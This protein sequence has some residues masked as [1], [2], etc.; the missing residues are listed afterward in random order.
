[1]FP[2]SAKNRILVSKCALGKRRFSDL[3]NVQNRVIRY[4][5]LG[6]ERFGFGASSDN[7][8]NAISF[9]PENELAAQKEGKYPK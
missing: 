9:A 1:M 4:V 6:C 7:I 3:L 5:C 8:E 2:H